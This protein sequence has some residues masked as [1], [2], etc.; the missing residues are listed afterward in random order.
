[1]GN[2]MTTK[3]TNL[4]KLFKQHNI[5]GYIVPSTDEYQ[6]EY[7][8]KSSRR[9][10]YIT[11]F[12]GSNGYVIIMQDNV[13]FFTDSRYTLQAKNE[14]PDSFEKI[15]YSKLPEFSLGSAQIGYNPMLFTQKQVDNLLQKLN[16][17]T[18]ENDLVD[19]IWDNRPAK[20]CSNAYIYDMKYAGQSV[21]DKIIEIRQQIKD[22]ADYCL[23]TNPATVCWALNLRAS[24]IEFCPIMLGRLLVS[25]EKIILFTDISRISREIKEQLNFVSFVAEEELQKYLLAIEDKVMIDPANCP[26]GLTRVIKHKVLFLNQS[27]ALVFH[28]NNI[29]IDGAKDAHVKDAVA[30]CEALAWVEVQHKS[31]NII[32]EYEIGQKLTHFRSQQDGYVM[33]SFPSIIGFKDNGAIIHYRALE[34]NSKKI[35]GDGVLLLDSGAHYLGG[36]TD[37]T[38]N[39]VFGNPSSEV[40]KRY[41]QVL[42]GHIAITIQHFPENTSGM[43]LDVLARM[44]LWNDGVDYGHGTGHGVGNFLSVHEGSVLSMRPSFGAIKPGTILS[45]EPGFY[46]DGEYGIRVENL[47]YTKDLG[48]GF[49]AFENLTLVP[50][51]HKLIDF[52]II[53]KAELGY[54]TNYYATIKSKVRPYLSEEAKNW[55]DRE[56]ILA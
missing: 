46:K 9:L 27:I 24:D 33:D 25:E 28:K 55:L 54:L 30:L 1:M 45:N 12:T 22:K 44:F 39:L 52:D 53:N 6:N 34:A 10:E 43:N 51:C 23:I 56:I 18:L 21:E 26:I 15:N 2:T 50:Y 40:K 49:L 41:T 42:K 35:T 5:D 11:G 8:P 4:R 32:T 20:P 7:T 14:L 13:H 38:R 3:I 37:V 19:E 29:E 16:L 31:G 17:V 47:L 36:T 48:N